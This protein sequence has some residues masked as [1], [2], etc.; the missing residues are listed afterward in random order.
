MDTITELSKDY[1]QWKVKFS[2]KIAVWNIFWLMF[3]LAVT[4]YDGITVIHTHDYKNGI[5][6]GMMLVTFVWAFGYLI[7]TLSDLKTDKLSLKFQQEL[8]EKQLAS[9][10][11]EQYL[12]AKQAYEQMIIFSQPN[13]ESAINYAA[14]TID[15]KSNG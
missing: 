15:S 5:A 1:Y 4:F 12:A 2:K 3:C 10:E 8:Y 14:I 6:F 7:S 11:R 9:K 13:D